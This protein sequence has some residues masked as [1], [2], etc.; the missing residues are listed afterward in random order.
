M[1]AGP[2][3]EAVPM[4]AAHIPPDLGAELGRLGAVRD[5]EVQT[6]RGSS[7]GDAADPAGSPV[8]AALRWLGPVVPEQLL[9]AQ[10]LA[11]P[12]LV[13]AGMV[14]LSPLLGQPPAG[15]FYMVHSGDESQAVT[16][17]RFLEMLRPGAAELAAALATRLAAHPVAAPLLAGGADVTGEAPIAA[18]HGTAYLALAVAAAS[19]VLGDWRSSFLAD[20]PAA[21]AVGVAVGTPVLL[22]RDAPV[23]AGDAAALLAAKARQEYTMPA[24]TRTGSWSS[25][26]GTLTGKEREFPRK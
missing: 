5:E 2:V 4:I 17:V 1:L 8:L 7:A 20:N 9:A 3:A 24:R 6:S 21:A 15:S 25:T 11:V 13:L 12:D 22:L 14:D 10:E 19:A 23:P 16:A 26:S 18:A